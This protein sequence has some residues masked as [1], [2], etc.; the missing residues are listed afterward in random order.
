MT[1]APTSRFRC[2]GSLNGRALLFDAPRCLFRYRLTAEGRALR[3]PWVI[4]H[5]GPTERRTDAQAVRYVP[6][7]D[8]IGPMGPDLV[9]VAP[10]SVARFR[11]DH[12]GREAVSFEQVDDA[13]LR[14]LR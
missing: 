12:G 14:S 1:V 5:Y 6:G 8:V 7:S 2:G 11:Q 4:E 3:D 9:P 13:L 10:E